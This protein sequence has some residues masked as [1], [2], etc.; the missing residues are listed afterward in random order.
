MSKTTPENLEASSQ[1]QRLL[2]VMEI[3]RT[4]EIGCP[5]DIEQDF[6]SISPYTIE[7]AYEVAQAIANDDMLELKEELGDLLLQVVYHAQIAKEQQAFDFEDVVYAICK[8]MIGR[9]PHVFGTQ[10][11]RKAGMQKGMWQAIKAKEKQA[12]L[13]ELERRGITPRKQGLL[14]EVPSTFPALLEA[15]KLQRHASTV[16]FD[17]GEAAPVLAK[18][19]EEITELEEEVV[20]NSPDRDCIEAELGDVLFAVANLARHLD[21]LPEAALK[22]TNEKFRK[23]FAHIEAGAKQQKRPLNDL[24]LEEMEELWQAAKAFDLRKTAHRR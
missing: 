13:Q 22:R 10:E 24:S 2:E 20:A 14:D 11:Q 7:E 19:R 21:I 18:I 15:E 1:I 6:A 8:K 23:R 12:K 16:G 9:H 5:W 3:L 4:P 17:W